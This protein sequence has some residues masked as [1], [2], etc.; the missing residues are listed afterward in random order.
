MPKAISLV[1]Y[2]ALLRGINVG[3]NHKV[4]MADLKKQFESLGYT[5]VKTILASGNVLFSAPAQTEKA[6]KEAIQV[7]L[8]KTYG[9]FIETMIRPLA[10]IEE[11]IK[12]DPFRKVTVTNAT[13]LYVSFF[14][15]PPKTTLKIPYVSTNGALQIL[16]IRGREVFSVITLSEHM[17]TPDAMGEMTKAF[18]KNPVTVRNWNT[19]LKMMK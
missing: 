2:V 8:E 14:E 7:K 17:S 4:P 3:G 18:G 19:V 6:I 10:V 16:D 12:A 13:L 9:F 5:D 1:R 11:L 15:N